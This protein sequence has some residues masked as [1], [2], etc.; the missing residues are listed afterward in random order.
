MWVMVQDSSENCELIFEK[1]REND[2]K[3]WIDFILIIVIMRNN[4]GTFDD[5][6]PLM[7]K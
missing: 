1:L 6:T 7:S 5:N 2:K 3:N 4:S